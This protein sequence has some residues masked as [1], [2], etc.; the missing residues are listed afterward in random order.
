MDRELKAVELFVEGYN[1][2]QAVIMAYSYRIGMVKSSGHPDHKH[3]AQT[4]R[5]NTDSYQTRQ[6]CC[7]HQHSLPFLHYRNTVT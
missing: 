2:A 1:C 7:G 6:I 5:S 4:T 3:H